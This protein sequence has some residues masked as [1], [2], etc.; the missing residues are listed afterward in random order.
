MT[1]II[2]FVSS[3]VDYI[4]LQQMPVISTYLNI[5]LQT[6]PNYLLVLKVSTKL[7]ND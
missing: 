3:T 2:T 5:W 4:G 1:R 6:K 7:A